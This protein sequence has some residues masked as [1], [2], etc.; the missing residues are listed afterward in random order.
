MTK[1]VNTNVFLSEQKYDYLINIYQK[2]TITT[3]IISNVLKFIQFHIKKKK[4][5][6][7]MINLVEGE[8]HCFLEL[9]IRILQLISYI[10]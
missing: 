6:C 7:T 10:W 9:F 4:K 3:K 8:E 5:L 1:M 2:I